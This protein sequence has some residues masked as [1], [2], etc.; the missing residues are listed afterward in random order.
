MAEN[1]GTIHDGTQAILRGIRVDIAGVMAGIAEVRQ[2]LGG[3]ERRLDTAEAVQRAT[4]GRLE[5]V[6]KSVTMMSLTVEA[7]REKI[8]KA[9]QPM[10]SRL[11]TIEARVAAIEEHSGMVRV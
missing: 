5:S 11:N 1:G 4:L 3:G 8:L 9:Q 2:K 6:T 7:A 10:G